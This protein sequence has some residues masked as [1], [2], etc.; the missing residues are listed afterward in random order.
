M[1]CQE[2]HHGRLLGILL[3]IVLGSACSLAQQAICSSTIGEVPRVLGSSAGQKLGLT[4]TELAQL[5]KVVP[6]GR[7]LRLAVRLSE[8]Q[9]VLLYENDNFFSPDANLLLARD[10][11]VDTKF[12]MSSLPLKPR[13]DLDVEW[14]KSFDAFEYAHSCTNDMQFIFLSFQAGNAGGTFVAVVQDAKGKVSIVPLGDVAQGRLLISDSN[15]SLVQLWD[16]ASKDSTLCT[17][18][19]KHYAVTDIDLSSG[20][21][22]VKAEKTTKRT[23]DG[24]EFQNHPL[25]FAAVGPAN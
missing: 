10:G 13:E 24:D 16:V 3:A 20:T 17:G 14:R 4:T 2:V 23:Y 18:C 12:A 5:R 25:R 11:S 1:S 7:L 15:P 9:Y 8:D 6:K 21:R 22:S 19:P